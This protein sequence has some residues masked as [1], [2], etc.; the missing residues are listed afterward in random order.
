MSNL[1]YPLDESG[2]SPENKVNEFQSMVTLGNDNRLI[3]P[4]AAP[5]FKEGLVVTHWPSGKVLVENSDFYLG[6]RYRE[7]ENNL[8][9]PMFGA[10]VFT[11]LGLEGSFE[12]DYQT[13]GGN[14]VKPQPMILEHLT[15]Y[16]TNPRITDWENVVNKAPS[17]PV[18]EHTY[19]HEDHVNL[20]HIESEL[21]N[22]KDAMERYRQSVGD[23]TFDGLTLRITTLEEQMVASGLNAH[24]FA[25]NDPHNT[26]YSQ[27]NALGANQASVNGIKAFNKTLTEFVKYCY[28]N[29][30]TQ[31]DL[32]T[33]MPLASN[34]K[35]L[36]QL[37]LPTTS[38]VRSVDGKVSYSM[39][40]QLAELLAQGAIT[41]SADDDTNGNGVA[42]MRAGSNVL[43]IR[44]NGVTIN[45]D[46]LLYNG[47]V[48][49]HTGNVKRLMVA[50]NN[51]IYFISV[52]D[53]ANTRV[54]GNGTPSNPLTI[55]GNL[56]VASTSVRGETTITKTVNTNNSKAIA[57]T[58][59]A[60]I[61]AE[62]NTK[63]D[64][65]V[66]LNGHPVKDSPTL[67]ATDINLGEVDNTNDLEK[68]ISDPQQS[69]L[70][71]YAEGSHSHSS[72]D[73]YIPLASA[74]QVG[75]GTYSAVG[76]PY[77]S[78]DGEL[79]T[80]NWYKE[81]FEEAVG[82]R[83][84][85]L[86]GV[87]SDLLPVVSFG[88]P[89]YLPIP[90]TGYFGGSGYGGSNY[91]AVME[92]GKRIVLL[93]NGK[94]Y[95]ERA[96]YYHII[97]LNEDDSLEYQY[98]LTTQY[99]PKLL[100]TE[101]P[102][103]IIASCESAMV[104]HTSLGN[105]YLI[106]FND[107]MDSSKHRAT[108]VTGNF[109]K[110]VDCDDRYCFTDANVS[111]GSGLM[112][113][114]NRI[115]KSQLGSKLP[116]PTRKE[117]ITGN[118][119]DGAPTSGEQWFYVNSQK[120]EAAATGNDICVVTDDF[121][122]GGSVRHA[123]QNILVGYEDGKIRIYFYQRPYF[124]RSA[125]AIY[126]GI[127]ELS[128]TVDLR[129]AN[130]VVMDFVPD[131]PIR[132]NNSGHFQ[133]GNMA[134]SGSNPYPGANPN[135]Q[136]YG[137]PLGHE[138]EI[139]QSNYGTHATPYIYVCK[140]YDTNLSWFASLNSLVRAS[141]GLANV[142]LVGKTYSGVSFGTKGLAPVIGSRAIVRTNGGSPML[143]KLNPTS[144]YPGQGD[145]SF[146]YSADSTLIDGAVANRISRIP[147]T[148]TSSNF[149]G[150]NPASEK[151]RGATWWGGGQTIDWEWDENFS[152]T[153]TLASSVYEAI[154]VFAKAEA[155]KLTSENQL[156]EVLFVY[157]SHIPEVPMFFQYTLMTLLANGAKR[158]TIVVGTFDCNS[159]QNP[160]SITV[161]PRVSNAAVH[162]NNGTGISVAESAHDGIQI[163]KMK[164]GEWV[165]ICKNA[166]Y[167]GYV[168][169]SGARGFGFR[170]A[171]N[172]YDVTSYV[173]ISNYAYQPDG[174]TMFGTKG[175]YAMSPEGSGT[176]ILG[177]WCDQDWSGIQSNQVLWS[178]VAM[179]N[180][181]FFISSSVPTYAKGNSSSLPAL[182]FD[183]EDMYPGEHQNTA[184]YLYFGHGT[185]DSQ[186]YELL[187][188]KTPDTN[189]ST[190]LGI[191]ETDANG[192]T[193][194]DINSVLKWGTLKELS[195]H[196]AD[197]A[198]HGYGS[199]DK[200]TFNLDLI[201]NK[202]PTNT[203]NPPTFLEVFNTWYRFSHKLNNVY[204]ALPNEINS[205]SYNAAN[206]S[207]SC[208]INSASTIGFVSQEPYTDYDFDTF[209]SSTNSDDDWVGVVIAFEIDEY[210]QE[211]SL[212]LMRATYA[213]G[214][215]I[216]VIH[217]HV[218]V[219]GVVT[220]T[221]IYQGGTPTPVGW[222]NAGKSRLKII[223]EG[224][225]Y[226]MQVYS[227]TG[228]GY[229]SANVDTVVD[230]ITL[231]LED[232]PTMEIFKGSSRFGYICASQA[233][234]T[235]ANITRPDSDGRSYYGTNA[236][237]QNVYHGNG[238]AWIVAKNMSFQW[239]S[240]V[241]NGRIRTAILAAPLPPGYSAAD[242]D[243][244]VS[245]TGWKYDSTSNGIKHAECLVDKVNGTYRF[246]LES[247]NKLGQYAEIQY[248]I[249]VI[250]RP[251][252]V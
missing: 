45:T 194:I 209:V 5:F 127:W 115:D 76:A 33:L 40:N 247:I 120:K 133:F 62:V 165:V 172:S 28:D 128:C 107:T 218:T 10:I 151:Q 14:Y 168:G 89:D 170:V 150:T 73:I 20:H 147:Y 234:S 30:V 231:D 54:T 249:Y 188:E 68:P 141:I 140:R 35:L 166:V 6:Y 187:T 183:L 169:N 69:L 193:R 174:Y 138:Y 125:G 88:S 190:Y 153:A 225:V 181:T 75:Y 217:R 227:F 221:K 110:M 72:E 111:S 57:S 43:E 52:V 38:N 144:F 204:P 66:L 27:A 113:N 122:F 219:D 180:W 90:A 67:T 215:N 12:V 63:L 203:L 4:N 157:S 129:N 149:D 116:Q 79:S 119:H 145:K 50:V 232:Y 85:T 49:I 53:G 210:G 252:R 93:R 42:A 16:L 206:D 164:N 202:S 235:W 176:T 112:V 205:W 229:E 91:A 48:V 82:Y 233:S 56:P 152:G 3:V 83:D 47:S 65:G 130:R 9:K 26:T 179:G 137:N 46:S 60:K 87:P 191:I 118:R 124:S 226:T 224:D 182:S 243:I 239:Q 236:L 197:R 241:T 17:Y 198:A 136:T 156:G 86:G 178:S 160:T 70:D 195:D 95:F 94:D 23:K 105:Y 102:T 185:K 100:P 37:I 131:F 58:E 61:T 80:I 1:F 246:E 189:E 121:S 96:L 8:S 177:N 158:V 155:R 146:G 29:G 208:T 222:R 97:K 21:D 2:T 167:I 201:E 92:A 126:G 24:Q 77:E 192:I 101:R 55:D 108:Q 199:I 245:I 19:S 154:K 25:T 36:E 143:A 74:T 216:E 22:L 114:L 106:E 163:G 175:I 223:R 230:T 64:K 84:N 142:P 98:P 148:F 104:V 173:T 135:N 242:C 212:Y 99:K 186:G 15:N 159:R 250:A 31:N 39:G 51:T 237:L 11:N 220:T 103:Q 13:I 251:S 214:R 134:L 162:Y 132:I 244:A 117:T 18:K 171:S 196:T 211:H 248:N 123:T 139:Y 78:S 161:L 213:N 41:I 59:L 200:T 240:G 7:M 44:S 81:K 32:D 109:G 207:I 71:T 184:F 34:H 228:A 238:D